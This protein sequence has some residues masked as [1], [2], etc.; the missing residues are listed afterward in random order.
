LTSI[1]LTGPAQALSVVAQLHRLT[2]LALNT[3]PGSGTDSDLF[4]TVHVVA[5]LSKLTA[6]DLENT[7]MYSRLKALEGLDPIVFISMLDVIEHFLDGCPEQ[8]ARLDTVLGSFRALGPCPALASV[9]LK[10]LEQYLEDAVKCHVLKHMP[11]LTRVDVPGAQS[12]CPGG[13]RARFCSAGEFLDVV[14]MAAPWRSVSADLRLFGGGLSRV[15]PHLRRLSD[16][17]IWLSGDE[18]EAAALG[19]QPSVSKL[20]LDHCRGV[21]LVA[22][23]ARNMS[24]VRELVVLHDAGTEAF[25]VVL[26]SMKRLR[27]VSVE[28]LEDEVLLGAAMLLEGRAMRIVARDLQ[29]DRAMF[30][31]GALGGL[32]CQGVVI[33]PAES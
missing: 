21:H 29:V 24:N 7:D 27:Q 14:P 1:S 23:V 8:R 33:E 26:A 9:R 19:V 4:A 10:G 6:L 25:Y 17:R 22:L 32:G 2:S 31:T 28:G 16:A 15:A 30:L 18:G 3:T 5:A 13:L 20:T 12:P 11:G